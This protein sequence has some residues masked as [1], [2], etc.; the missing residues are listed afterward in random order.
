M[1]NIAGGIEKNFVY[2][3]TGNKGQNGDILEYDGTPKHVAVALAALSKFLKDLKFKKELQEKNAKY[4]KVFQFG[5]ESK[6]VL[7]FMT[8]SFHK[9]DS[10]EIIAPKGKWKYYDIYSNPITP[11]ANG[12]IKLEQAPIWAMANEPM[13]VDTVKICNIKRPRKKIATKGFDTTSEND[14]MNRTS[15]NLRKFVNR[16]FY[17]EIVDDGLGGWTDEGLSDMRNLATGKHTLGG[18]PFDII[19][20]ETNSGKSAVVLKSSGGI[21]KGPEKVTIPIGFKTSRIHFLH[22]ATYC[23][24]P[25]LGKC[26]INYIDGS[27]REIPM[28]NGFELVETRKVDKEL[29]NGKIGW[30]GNAASGRK[31]CLSV[32]TWINPTPTLDVESIEIQSVMGL[33]RYALL[34]LTCDVAL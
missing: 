18:I 20:P 3:M 8:Y 33:P 24:V 7:F 30:I 15:I 1:S 29:K 9:G 32:F 2:T 27:K 34:A 13:E 10:M 5:G 14:W 31:A 23:V 28:R 6:T 19:N 25:V 16:G 11:E 21:Y 22:T 26:I 17:D 12:K 4:L